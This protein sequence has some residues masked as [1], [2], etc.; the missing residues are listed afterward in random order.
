MKTDLT[1][2]QTA[3]FTKN[4]FLEVELPHEAVPFSLE[5][6]L[7]RKHEELKR[8][9]LKKLGPLALTLTGKKRLRLGL[10][11]WM[12]AERRPTK[13]CPLNERFCIQNLALAVAI[14]GD[15]SFPPK[16][17]PLGILPLPSHSKNV[18][19]FKPNLLLDWPH[20]LSD[21]FFILFALPNAVYAH[22]PKDPDA[23]FL[24]TLGYQ[25][26]DLLKA[27]THPLILI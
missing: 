16:K 17:S 19:F 10:D 27:E 3:F 9:I 5:R 6:D 15:P 2:T 7:W 18:L 25:Y 22:N 14:A 12:T 1:E 21:L 26:G 4:G 23:Y 8:F 13:I 11:S 24:K 20:V